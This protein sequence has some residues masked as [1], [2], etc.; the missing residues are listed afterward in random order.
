MDLTRLSNW[1]G[2][3]KTYLLVH[4]ILSSTEN[5]HSTFHL[6]LIVLWQLVTV[7]ESKARQTYK[8]ERKPIFS[9][10]VRS[11]SHFALVDTESLFFNIRSFKAL[12]LS[13]NEQA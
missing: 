4:C 7:I 1:I 9:F 6:S 12:N 3:V 10:F 8:P 13:D 2:L 5:H 11:Y